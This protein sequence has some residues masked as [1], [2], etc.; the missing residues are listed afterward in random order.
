[1]KKK[2]VRKSFR[3]RLKLRRDSNKRLRMHRSTTTKATQKKKPTQKRPRKTLK[4]VEAEEEV[5]E[6]SK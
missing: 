5:L 4:R 2:L 3:I 1:M 6:E